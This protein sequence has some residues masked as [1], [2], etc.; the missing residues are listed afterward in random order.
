MIKE[1]LK[2]FYPNKKPSDIFAEL[3]IDREV[4]IATE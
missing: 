2:D 4:Y 1:K 3:K